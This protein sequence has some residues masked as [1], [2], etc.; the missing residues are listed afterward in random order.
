MAESNVV[1]VERVIA[2]EPQA[3]FDL[4]ADPRRHREIDGSGRAGP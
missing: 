1:T 2:A 4:L 3:I